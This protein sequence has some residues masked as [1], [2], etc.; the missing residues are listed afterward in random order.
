MRSL[1]TP[2]PLS[3]QASLFNLPTSI[4]ATPR[5]VRLW[6]L[7]PTPRVAEA[8]VA[9]VPARRSTRRAAHHVS[10]PSAGPPR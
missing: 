7:C 2:H 4:A 1:L 3:P 5:F 8:L 10:R 6:T 9:R